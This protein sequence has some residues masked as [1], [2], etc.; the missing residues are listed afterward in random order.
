MAGERDSDALLEAVAAVQAVE[1]ELAAARSRRD[2]QIRAAAREGM[3][4]RK[5]AKV[6]GI[7]HQ[8]MTQVV[9]EARSPAR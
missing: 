1:R 4:T 9:R 7:S 5:I 3:S 8:R 2:E 6:A